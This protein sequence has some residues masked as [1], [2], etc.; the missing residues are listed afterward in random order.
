L[1]LSSGV[2]A[3][4]PRP[5]GNAKIEDLNETFP[6]KISHEQVA[7][8]DIAVDDATLMGCP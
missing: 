1:A 4:L 3:Y 6:S 8:F 5:L 7:R 2:T